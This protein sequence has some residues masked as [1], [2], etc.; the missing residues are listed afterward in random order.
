MDAGRVDALK[1]LESVVVDVESG[2]K[3]RLADYAMAGPEGGP[4][5]AA[6]VV[7]SLRRTFAFD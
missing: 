3:Q 1:A 7:V 4:G 2:T 5:P 6:L